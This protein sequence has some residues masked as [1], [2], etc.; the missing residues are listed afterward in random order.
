MNINQIEKE[1]GYLKSRVLR[2]EEEI[3]KEKKKQGSAGDIPAMSSQL[4]EL[5]KTDEN[6]T[7]QP[8]IASPVQNPGKRKNERKISEVFVGKYALPVIAS[9]MVMIGIFV[10]AFMVWNAMPNILKAGFVFLIAMCCFGIGIFFGKEPRMTAFKNAMMGTGMTVLYA[11]IVLMQLAWSLIPELVTVILFIMWCVAGV[12]L[13]RY[14]EEKIFYWIAVTGIAV[15]SL[16]LKED[17]GRDLKSLVLCGIILAAFLASAILFARQF[18]EGTSLFGFSAIGI[19]YSLSHVISK[20]YGQNG[21]L[22]VMQMLII[23]SMFALA[24]FKDEILY[25]NN[26]ETG[27]LPEI[28]SLF[29]AFLCPMFIAQLEISSSGL[30]MEALA[31][32]L[33]SVLFLKGKK[34]RNIQS[35]FILPALLWA[36]AYISLY[37][38]DNFAGWALLAGILFVL[39]KR[40][41]E[42]SFSVQFMIV[43]ILHVAAAFAMFILPSTFTIESILLMGLASLLIN[44]AVIAY[45]S[46]KKSSYPDFIVSSGC[47]IANIYF[48]GYAAADNK[49]SEWIMAIT[50]I[51]L[52]L[53]LAQT[54]YLSK[55]CFKEDKKT[56][57][58]VLTSIVSW[59]VLNAYINV[60]S[61]V[62][63][64]II[65]VFSI[66]QAAISLYIF[67]ILD[68]SKLWNDVWSS[69]YMLVYMLVLTSKTV[70]WDYGIVLSLCIIILASIFIIIGFAMKKKG[71]R[72]FGLITII[73]SIVKMILVDISETN[74]FIRVV[75]F[76]LGGIVCFGISYAYN[77]LEKGLEE[78]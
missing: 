18:K 10:M 41:D 66:A 53:T 75:A 58:I 47:L 25:S 44:A 43:N 68:E 50:T 77:R 15:T 37:S 40:T 9:A 73:I 46:A 4:V 5:S 19:F 23:G 57:W 11:D 38:M 34:K 16:I 51:L 6:E 1:L 17:M 55:S 63:A 22:L 2:L 39:S 76:I 36:F 12:L 67:G 26:E 30:L 13:S 42:N 45:S 71:M 27:P 21:I 64:A 24:F 28:A 54:F 52:V 29:L 32:T 20:S 69:A 49:H 70:L 7:M 74:S 65:A 14:Y 3:E 56:G 35:F 31:V 59:M 48:L 62:V 78:N 72:L 33:F 8:I 61:T 60:H